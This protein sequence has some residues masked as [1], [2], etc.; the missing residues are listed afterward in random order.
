MPVLL[1]RPW[2]GEPHDFSLLDQQGTAR[3]YLDYGGFDMF[4]WTG[5]EKR[6]TNRYHVGI[7]SHI[8][9]ELERNDAGIVFGRLIDLSQNGAKC[10]I[11]KSLQFSETVAWRLTMP[12]LDIAAAI[13]SKVIW[14]RTTDTSN[15]LV[16]CSFDEALPNVILDRLARAGFI[17]R[18][19]HPR[20]ESDLPGVARSELCNQSSPVSVVDYSYGGFRMLSDQPKPIGAKVLLNFHPHGS[21]FGIVRWCSTEGDIHSVGCEFRQQS[22][23]GQGA[24][25]IRDLHQ[26]QASAV[27]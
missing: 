22:E 2:A 26:L 13:K 9:I 16:G 20:S 8:S 12:A 23:H 6:Q 15:W 7:E 3:R 24:S 1:G 17:N 10:C 19:R 27:S 25:L 18:R 5:E 21:V 11:N 14:T 4:G